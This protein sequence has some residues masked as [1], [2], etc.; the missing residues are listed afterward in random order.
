VSD[1]ALVLLIILIAVLLFRAPKTL[2]QIGAA[3][4]RGVR[5]ARSNVARDLDGSAEDDEDRPASS[6]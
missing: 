4:G 1:I 6:S 2:P 5:E 3:L